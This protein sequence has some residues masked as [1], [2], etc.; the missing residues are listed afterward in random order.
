[1]INKI[2]NRNPRDYQLDALRY[3]E[4]V[5]HPAYFI[6]PRLGKTFITIRDIKR[7]FS[8]IGPVLIIAPYSALYGW[9]R[10]LL[11]EGF[12]QNDI[13]YLTG[14][15]AE[16]EK[17]I[18]KSGIFFLINKEA[19]LSFPE[20]INFDWQI[21]V[22]DEATYL[23]C[24]PCVNWSKR[25]GKRPNISKFYTESFRHVKRRYVLTGTP[26]TESELDYYMILKFL[27]PSIL[28][29]S[30]IWAF[31]HD[32]FML[33]PPHEYAITTKGK[34]F[35][36]ERLSK[37]C[38]FLARKDINLGGEQI[39]QTRKVTLSPKAR[40]IYEKMLDDFILI[41][42]E[43]IV[44]VTEFNLE[45]ISWAR[46]LF[47]GFIQNEFIFDHKIEELRNLIEG[48]LKNKQLIIWCEFTNEI[49]L[50]QK[51]LNKMGIL[52]NFINGDISPL[53]RTEIYKSFNRGEYQILIANPHCLQY[54][55]DL[56]GSEIMIFYSTPLGLETRL[57]AQD[58]NITIQSSESYIIDIVCEGTIE[59]D[60]IESLQNKESKRQLIKRIVDRLK[61]KVLSR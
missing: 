58:R 53:S 38:F 56:S 36:T 47:G 37:Y 30:N 4:N 10:E 7:Q 52:N 61:R 26:M 9:E 33:I 19:Y 54:G 14:D 32:N 28:G 44:D 41:L 15:R 16:K 23:K 25:Y 18:M 17:S 22:S 57:Q 11:L 3:S 49:Y 46:S 60:F 48:E 2:I 39:F 43:T 21:V 27:D 12:N 40:K 59:E 1:M 55:V 42:D 20:I 13:V 6:E 8:D 24:T 34:D 45:I 5:Y 35:L 31:K 51:V 29:Y 50:I